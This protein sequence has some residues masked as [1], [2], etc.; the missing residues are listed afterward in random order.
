MAKQRAVVQALKDELTKLQTEAEQLKESLGEQS[1][2]LIH[3][4]RVMKMGSSSNCSVFPHIYYTHLLLDTISGY[5]LRVTTFLIS[6]GKESRVL[7]V[8]PPNVCYTEKLSVHVFLLEYTL[9]SVYCVASIYRLRSLHLSC[10]VG[11]CSRLCQS[12]KFW[13]ETPHNC[14]WHR[15]W[16][17]SSTKGCCTMCLIWKHSCSC[18]VTSTLLLFLAAPLRQIRLQADLLTWWV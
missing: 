15:W 6:P 9:K 7:S 2:F 16:A 3:I 8:S 12:K 5:I 1:T 4:C 11:Q 10:A 17:D 13:C 18:Q 14:Q